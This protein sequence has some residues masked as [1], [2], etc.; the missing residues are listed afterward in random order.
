MQANG[1]SMEIPSTGLTDSGSNKP[2]TEL[3]KQSNNLEI[4]ALGIA[5]VLVIF[6]AVPNFFGALSDLRGEECSRRLTLAAN[7]LQHLAIKNQT[8]P[9]EQICQLFDL[10]QILERV[11]R[12]GSLISTSGRYIVFYKIGVEPDCADTGNH[13]VTLTLGDDGKI[14]PPVCSLAEGDDGE[15]YRQNKLH[16]CLMEH[17]TGDLGLNASN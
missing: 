2:R 6:F 7:C 8:K 5:F 4:I 3:L 13:K 15:T 1:D 11:Q 10:N 16:V 9:G 14:I 12:G 17:V